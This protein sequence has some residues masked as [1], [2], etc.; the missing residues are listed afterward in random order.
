MDAAT[1][2]RHIAASP[3]ARRWASRAVALFA[4]MLALPV[5]VL[6]AV[7]IALSSSG[8]GTSAVGT[9]G[10]I[11]VVYAP[12]YEA[13]GS[14]YAVNP[15]VLAALHKTESDYS[16]DP[17]AFRP[18]SAGAVGPMQFLP[19]TWS[20]YR[21]AFRPIAARRPASYPHACSPHGCIDDDFDSIA[22]AASYL[23]TLGADAGL[24]RRTLEAL[25]R[26][27][28][29]PPASI[30]YAREAF[31]LAQELERANASATVPTPGGGAP[32]V[33]RLVAVADAIAELHIPYCY[34]GGHV[35]P[36]RPTHGIYC[37]DEADNFI[38]GSAFDGLDCSG[39]VSMLLQH[40]GVA[41][42]TLDST[43]YMSF[44]SPGVGRDFTI[45][46]NETH[47][48]VELAGHD[49]GTSDLNAS[50]GPGW[51]AHATVGFTPRHLAGV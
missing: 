1:V 49:W 38:S 28:G 37:H 51:A 18:N 2:G 16:R 22:A 31:A 39:A 41:T 42:P 30:P 29:T 12:M 23:H 46:A 14:A 9:A 45:W 13:T 7:V 15:Y 6:L 50:G 3:A 44:G 11:P 34:G 32:L 40:A 8:R 36:A 47:V 43:E 19:A 10:G 48:F 33:R 5:V 24:D 26:Y 4:L 27:K 20:P 21:H 35:T 25:V 17:S